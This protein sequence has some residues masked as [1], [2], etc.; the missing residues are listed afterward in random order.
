MAVDAEPDF[1]KDL[2]EKLSAYFPRETV[3]TFSNPLDALAYADRN[4]V[5]LLFTDVRLCPIDGYELIGALREKQSFY[6]YVIS[7]TRERP[8]DLQ[9]MN[10]NG[11]FPKPISR[12]ELAKIRR[13]LDF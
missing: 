13:E 11:F 1:L 8:D 12:E 2:Y 4:R 10:V 6:A 7:G 5:D 9:W 3:A